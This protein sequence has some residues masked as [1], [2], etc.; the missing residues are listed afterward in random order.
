MEKDFQ[1]KGELFEISKIPDVY[2]CIKYDLQHNQKTLQYERANE[3][4]M[5]SKALADI[6]V[7]QV[8][9]QSS[10]R[11]AQLIIVGGFIYD[12]VRMFGIECELFDNSSHSIPNINYTVVVFTRGGS[13]HLSTCNM[14]R[15]TIRCADDYAPFSGDVCCSGGILMTGVRNHSGG[16]VVHWSELLFAFPEEDAL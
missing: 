16:E 9:S 15:T 12:H 14:L 13:S 2:D 1:L 10:C 3:L 11:S 6:I 7:P 8:G 4:F 5:C